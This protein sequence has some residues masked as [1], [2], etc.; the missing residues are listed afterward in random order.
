[1]LVSRSEILVYLFLDLLILGILGGVPPEM[2]QTNQKPQAKFPPICKLC[3]E[4]QE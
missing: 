1:M 2:L 3:T 4:Q